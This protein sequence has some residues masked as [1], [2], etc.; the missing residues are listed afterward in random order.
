MST[1]PNKLCVKG[2]RISLYYATKDDKKLIYDMSMEPEIADIMYGGECEPHTW[3]EY[4]NEEDEFYT[5]NPSKNNY[6]LIVFN[7]QIIGAVSY[8]YNKSKISNMELDIWM[9]S[10]QYAGKGL[11]VETLTVLMEFLH[12]TYDIDTFIIRPWIK[13]TRAVQA[14]KKC[15]FKVVKNFVPTDYYGD[16]VGEWGEGDYGPEE[17]VNMV[18]HI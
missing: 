1:I 7:N 16:D 3:E 15:G 5:G 2:N 6:L 8:S 17:T 18:R 9:S 4:S 11:G 14:Y 13:N 12:N 10:L